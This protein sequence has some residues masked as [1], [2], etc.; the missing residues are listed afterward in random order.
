MSTDQAKM[1]F[2]VSA[3]RPHQVDVTGCPISYRL[4][5][6]GSPVLL[7]MGLG[8]DVSAWQDHVVA[9]SDAF[10]CILV[11]NRGVGQSGKPTGP[12]STSGMADDCARVIAGVTDEPVA[13]IG[14]S[15]G[16]AIA[17]ELALRH[18]SV[19]SSLLL[20]STWGRCDAHLSQ[21]FEHLCITHAKLAPTEFAQ[22]LQLRIW[23]PS[24]FSGHLQELLDA[25]D[26]AATSPVPHHAFEAQCTACTSHDALSRLGDIRVPT[27]ITFGRDDSFT[28]PEQ[29][30]QVHRAIPGSHLEA[31]PGG[32]AH[33]WENLKAFN[34]LTLAWLED[35]DG[36]QGK[37]TA[38]S[39][40][41]AADR[42]G[43]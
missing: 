16:G 9:Y 39:A 37:R 15:M 28:V 32:H 5:G 31:F 21:V 18:A 1:R 36:S 24:Y 38:A 43:V 29:A 30:Q 25:R 41:I 11:D 7:I 10:T 6:A 26:V 8:A 13:V 12:Y 22:L 19:V 17:Q 35:H 14:L 40:T 23:S 34:D 3:L 33:H 20:V 27:L 42:K 2:E 4:A